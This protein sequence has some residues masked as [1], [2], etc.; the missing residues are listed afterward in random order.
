MCKKFLDT[1]ILVL[2]RFILIYR[3]NI[4]YKCKKVLT[5][6]ID[7]EKVALNKQGDRFFMAKAQEDLNIVAEKGTDN[8]ITKKCVIDKEK[9]EFKAN[10]VVG[11]CE[12][13]VNGELAGKVKLYSD[14]DIKKAGIFGNLKDNFERIFDNGV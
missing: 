11:Y 12:V 6:G 2:P 8:K 3:K 14:R 7:V 1:L 10:Q 5:K 9:K 13:Y 4:F